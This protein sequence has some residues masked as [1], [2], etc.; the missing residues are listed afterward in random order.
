MNLSPTVRLSL[1]PKGVWLKIASEF[2]ASC[3]LEVDKPNRASTR[4][5]CRSFPSWSCLPAP[6]ILSSACDG[7]VDFGI[8]GIDVIEERRGSNGEILVLHG[9]L[10]FRALRP[11][12]GRA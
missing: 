6:E 8:T 3:G 12:P 1:P 7:S 9:T 2:L 10:G 11:G 4:P 5:V